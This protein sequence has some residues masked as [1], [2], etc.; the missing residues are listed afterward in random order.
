MTA[1]GQTRKGPGR[2]STGAR[3]RILEAGLETLLEEG[4]A[5]L[6]YAK[7]AD[8]A[9][10]NKSLISY[11]FDTKQGLV[12]AVA[13]LVGERITG[14]VLEEIRDTTRV[15]GLAEGLVTGLWNVMDEDPRMARLYFDLSAVSVIDD[16]VRLAL[17][18]VKN[19]WRTVIGEYLVRA[20]VAPGEIDAASVYLVAGIQGLA[21]ER[22]DEED[23]E[24][25]EQA[26]RLF[27]R[28][29]SQAIVPTGSR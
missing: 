1:A 12:G 29:T 7:V 26:R 10:E 14:E 25:L 23:P 24:R 6:S 5:G 13:E 19:G 4:F 18:E 16:Q 28:A 22:L 17:R 9:G 11:Y 15:E 20:G 3:E 8:R 21:I 27:V 2:P